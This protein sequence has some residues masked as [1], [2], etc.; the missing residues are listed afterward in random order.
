MPKVTFCRIVDVLNDFLIDGIM[1]ER[2]IGEMTL[3]HQNMQNVEDLIEPAQS[4]FTF[5]RGF[6]ALELICRLMAMNTYFVIRLR[7]NR[8]K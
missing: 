1:G 5:V 4:I 6:V 7:K 2:G 8:Y 3:I